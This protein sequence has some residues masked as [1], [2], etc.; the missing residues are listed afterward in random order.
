[1]DKDAVGISSSRANTG[2]P[3]H[4]IIERTNISRKAHLETRKSVNA[5]AK[6]FSEWRYHRAQ[7]AHG[8]LVESRPR[9]PKRPRPAMRQAPLRPAAA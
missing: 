2:E 9:G 6:L 5:P 8:G 7:R 1:M 4:T 3:G